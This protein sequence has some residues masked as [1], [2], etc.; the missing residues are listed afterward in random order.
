MHLLTLFYL[1]ISCRAS[2]SVYFWNTNVLCRSVF[3]GGLDC[4]IHPHCAA[5]PRPGPACF[6]GVLLDHCHLQDT[7]VGI[8]TLGTPLHGHSWRAVVHLHQFTQL[9]VLELRPV[10]LGSESWRE[11]AANIRYL[12]A[13]SFQVSNRL[14]W[15]VFDDYNSLA[16]S[17]RKHFSCWFYAVIFI[18]QASVLSLREGP[19]H[20][21][22]QTRGRL[23]SGVGSIVAAVFEMFLP[24]SVS[25]GGEKGDQLLNV[26]VMLMPL[27]NLLTD[28][29]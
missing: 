17:Q 3:V 12:K 13:T 7:A 11:R 28:W 21:H 24:V 6:P 19:E 15:L 14:R 27:F 22:L 26:E 8:K 2:L 20:W 16:H 25:C 9:W 23:Q 1:F 10:G 18:F 5:Q 4:Y 29:F